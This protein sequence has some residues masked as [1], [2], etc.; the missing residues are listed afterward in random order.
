MD[1][2]SGCGFVLLYEEPHL[3]RVFGEQY[4]DYCRR[5]NRWVPKGRMQ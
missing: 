3:R 2:R 1:A 4:K 5:V